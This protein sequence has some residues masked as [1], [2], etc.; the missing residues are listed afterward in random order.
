LVQ[1]RDLLDIGKPPNPFVVCAIAHHFT[2][3]SSMVRTSVLKSDMLASFA[4]QGFT[5]YD[6]VVL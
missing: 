3:V 4:L 6:S 1:R 2:I 5:N